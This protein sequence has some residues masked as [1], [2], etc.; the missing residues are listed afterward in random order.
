MTSLP[1]FV[2]YLPGLLTKYAVF[3]RAEKVVIKRGHFVTNNC[4]LIEILQIAT[5]ITEHSTDWARKRSD[6][7][8][9]QCLYSNQSVLQRISHRSFSSMYNRSDHSNQH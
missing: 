9:S 4:G 2:L 5:I 6:S 8:K 1:A 7:F 3:P